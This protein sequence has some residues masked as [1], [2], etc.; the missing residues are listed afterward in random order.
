MASPSGFNV[1]TPTVLKQCQDALR[2]L[3][4]PMPLSV[5]SADDTTGNQIF[6]LWNALGQELYAQYRWKEMEK[7]FGFSTVAGQSLYPLPEDWAGP[8]DQTEWDKTNHWSL[9]GQATPQQWQTLKSGIVALGPRIRYRYQGTSIEIFPTPA[10]VNGVFTPFD[11]A[12]E[13]YCS[14]WVITPDL[15]A[16]N[17]AIGDTDRAVYPNRLMVNGI[18]LKLWE[19]KGFDTTALTKNY[20]TSF[21]QAMARDQGAPRLSLSPRVS[22]I[23]IGPWN[24]SDGNWSSGPTGT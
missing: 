22:P 21:N 23:F 5:A 12:F 4:L 10:A 8:I 18:K 6:G 11:L 13:Y 24:I 17:E 1:S 19:I 20:D 7:H 14:G 9:I 3:G 15:N 16:A 2:E